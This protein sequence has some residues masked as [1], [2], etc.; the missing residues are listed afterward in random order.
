MLHGLVEMKIFLSYARPDQAFANALSEH[1][2]A[3]GHIVWADFLSLLPGDNWPLAIGRA[4][5]N[6]DAMVVILSPKSDKSET[7]RHEINYALGSERYSGKVIPVFIGPTKN[8]PWILDEFQSV[9]VN[10]NPAAAARQVSDLLR[11][12][13]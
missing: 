12:A 11:K 10:A 4:L 8:Y 1:L 3:K 9:R 2:T 13:G 6:C 7:Q 5:D